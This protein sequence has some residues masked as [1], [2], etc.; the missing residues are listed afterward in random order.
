MRAIQAFVAMRMLV[1]I[2]HRADFVLNA[3]GDVLVTVLG[4]ALLS[5]IYARVPDVRGWTR[6]EALVAWGMGQASLGVFWMVFPGLY[7]VNRLYLLDGELDRVMLRPLDPYLQILLENA[8]LHDVS[9]LAIGSAL[10]MVAGHA[11]AWSI[12][13]WAMLPVLITSGGLVIGGLLTG[14]C[15]IGFWVQHQGTAVGLAYQLTAYARY[16]VDFLP[17]GLAILVT[18]VI[19]FAFAGFIPACFYLDRAPYSQLAWATPLVGSACMAAG[20]AFFPYSLRRC[21]SAGT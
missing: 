20:Y 11:G 1:R 7:S 12:V 3:V 10:V 2:S 13:Q 16:P 19:P 21:A 17:R 8:N 14:L 15:A 9:M 5:V 18:G 4:I 6:D